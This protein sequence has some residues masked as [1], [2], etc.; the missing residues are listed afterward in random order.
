MGRSATLVRGRADDAEEPLAVGFNPPRRR[1]EAIDRSQE[2]AAAVG[3]RLIAVRR[4]P[5][6]SGGD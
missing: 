2:A 1:R 5:P 4:L 3:R 6:L